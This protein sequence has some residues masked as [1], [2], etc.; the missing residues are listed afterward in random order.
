MLIHRIVLLAGDI[1]SIRQIETN[2][3]DV[4]LLAQAT[5]V[6][7]SLRSGSEPATVCVGERKITV[8]LGLERMPRVEQHV[9]AV[10]REHN[11]EV[12]VEVYESMKRQV[13]DHQRRTHFRIALRGG[14][15]GY[16][17]IHNDC[18]PDDPGVFGS[19]AGSWLNNQFYLPEN[20]RSTLEF[21]EEQRQH[22]RVAAEMVS[23]KPAFFTHW[24]STDQTSRFGDYFAA[25][26]L[27][28]P[29]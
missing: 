2:D 22:Q 9:H 11:P 25:A 18:E 3:A 1:Q 20:Q 29:E 12:P 8:A 13:E 24:D 23:Y 15:V 26:M 27:L 6:L 21:E 17:L 4:D 10:W 28:N 14:E 7:V 5:L 19:V 16:S